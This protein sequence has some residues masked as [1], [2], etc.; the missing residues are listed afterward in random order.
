[1]LFAM[2]IR[3]QGESTL[4]TDFVTGLLNEWTAAS[5]LRFY[6][7]DDAMMPLLD[8]CVLPHGLGFQEDPRLVSNHPRKEI[9]NRF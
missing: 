9:K 8:F 2:V 3:N 6:G 1:M 4:T 7:K 5:A